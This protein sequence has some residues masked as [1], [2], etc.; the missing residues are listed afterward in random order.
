MNEVEVISKAAPFPVEGMVNFLKGFRDTSGMSTEQLKARA[1]VV[2]GYMLPASPAA[3]QW[4][5]G[6]L[7]KMFHSKMNP[8]IVGGFL[9]DLIC[10][11]GHSAG[12]LQ[13]AVMS[14][15]LP[16]YQRENEGGGSFKTVRLEPRKFSPSMQEIFVAF[17]DAEAELRGM[18]YRL[19]KALEL[20]DA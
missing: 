20:Q 10:S 18:Q 2:H 1:L 12:A 6:V 13:M 5:L 17:E 3:V 14:F 11:Q 15:I 4:S 9:F 7:L 8:E 19:E 16:K